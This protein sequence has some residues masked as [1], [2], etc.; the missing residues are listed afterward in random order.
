MAYGRKHLRVADIVQLLALSGDECFEDNES[1]WGSNYELDNAETGSGDSDNSEIY[2][3]N[4]QMCGVN[5]LDQL[6]SYYSPLCKTLKW[7][8]QKVVLQD[9]LRCY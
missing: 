3:Y 9:W 4:K 6:I 2:D 8:L 7:Y 1:D 5:R